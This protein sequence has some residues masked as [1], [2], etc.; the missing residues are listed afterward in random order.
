M[1]LR[2]TEENESIAAQLNAAGA[3]QEVFTTRI[4]DLE[5]TQKDLES[6]VAASKR[7][8]EAKEK[9]IRSLKAKLQVL[10]SELVRLEEEL[11]KEK[12]QRIRLMGASQNTH[13][14]HEVKTSA[15]EGKQ[16]LA[17]DAGEQ[18]STAMQENAL[19][20]EQIE[21]LKEVSAQLQESL[22]SKEELE[23]I[24]EM[25][26]HHDQQSKADLPP[27]PTSAIIS[28]NAMTVETANVQ[29]TEEADAHLS[30]II[31]PGRYTHIPQEIA[32]LLP[33]RKTWMPGIE[34]LEDDMG[35]VA[36]RIFDL[37]HTLSPDTKAAAAA[38][39]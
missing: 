11:L 24:A 15:E 21:Y 5:K 19:L 1:V 38:D 30:S 3:Q 32:A 29:G 8:C 22:S 4:Q 39:S 25:N 2:L 36:E 35:E 23:R 13:G 16:E 12:T 9:E 18:Y 7:E 6:T 10:G 31:T 20:K 37:L 26:I 28:A 14:N 34:T 33:R 17:G 27:P